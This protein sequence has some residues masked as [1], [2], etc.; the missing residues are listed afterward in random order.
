MEYINERL[1]EEKAVRPLTRLAENIYKRLY[2][3]DSKGLD[4]PRRYLQ[5][6]PRTVT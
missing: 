4:G 3:E 6:G 2:E 5:G 1:Y